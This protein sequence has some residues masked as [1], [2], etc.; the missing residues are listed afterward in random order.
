MCI[1]VCTKHVCMFAND[2][3]FPSLPLSHHCSTRAQAWHWS[4]PAMCILTIPKQVNTAGINNT[5]I[6]TDFTF[7]SFS[8]VDN[9]DWWQ[10][11]SVCP[12]GSLPTLQ[13]N[14]FISHTSLPTLLSHLIT[15]LQTSFRRKMPSRKETP[16]FSFM[17][18]WGGTCSRDL[19]WQWWT[20][21]SFFYHRLDSALLSWIP[22]P[23]S[24]SKILLPF[25]SGI[26]NLSLNWK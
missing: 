22:A 11:H 19:S 10:A 5:A 1:C 8:Q 9:Q 4:N 3:C 20:L 14:C 2:P 17:W 6:Q 12:Q 13:D 26:I 15:S 21:Y 18:I 24:F 16:L 25:P 23:V 7:T